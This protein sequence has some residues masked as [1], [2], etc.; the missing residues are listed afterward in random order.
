MKKIYV[1][2]VTKVE[3]WESIDGKQFNSEVDC[4]RWEESYRFTIEQGMKNVPHTIRSVYDLFNEGCE[5]EYYI[6]IA[7][8]NLDDVIIANAWLKEK[9][10]IYESDKERILLTPNDIGKVKTVFVSCGDCCYINGNSYK[11]ILTDIIHAFANMEKELND[12]INRRN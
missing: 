10:C 3:K 12:K 7:P 1:D 2:N 6:L 11:D 5:D 8:Q 9:Y 4:K